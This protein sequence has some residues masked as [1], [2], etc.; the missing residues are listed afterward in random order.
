MAA[1]DTPA[2][3]WFSEPCIMGIGALAREAEGGEPRPA[4][5]RAPTN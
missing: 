4:P 1:D 3:D 5:L 2:P